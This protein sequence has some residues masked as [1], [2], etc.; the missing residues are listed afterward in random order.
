NSTFKSL[1]VAY[2][3]GI[4]CDV[5]GNECNNRFES[6]VFISYHKY[7]N[8]TKVCS[9][10]YCIHSDIEYVNLNI[11]DNIYLDPDKYIFDEVYR[12]RD[13]IYE[14][15][16]TKEGWMKHTI[17]EDDSKT[18][19]V[20]HAGMGSGKTTALLNFLKSD[21]CEYKS[22]LVLTCNISLAADFDKNAR[23]RN[24]EFVSYLDKSEFNGKND[25]CIV[26][27]ESLHKI[28]R[29][30][31]I[32]VIDE[33]VTFVN[34]FRSTDTHTNLLISYTNFRKSIYNAQ[35]IILMDAF[36]DYSIIDWI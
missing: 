21:K 19:E 5:C 27:C 7:Y 26:Q 8:N 31:D 20:I 34:Q 10:I 35:K 12:F 23:Y 33:Y 28:K 14:L 13:S 15:G 11:Q 30:Y 16:H 18:I 1:E 22:V 25:K 32:V 17:D 3:E 36:R 6:S 9:K 4:Q 29:E 2:K 24:I